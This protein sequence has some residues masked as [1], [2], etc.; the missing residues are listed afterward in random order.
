MSKARKVHR[1]LKTTNFA[2]WN[3]NG[4][5][6]EKLRQEQLIQDMSQ[7]GICF[8]ALQ[9]TGWKTE[10]EVNGPKG[11]HIINFDSKIEGYR[12][13]GFY[14]S[15]EWKDRI[16]TSKLVNNRI[17][18]ARFKAWETEE[19]VIINVYG[20]TMMRTSDDPEMTE[21]FFNELKEVYLKE[22]RKT[23]A[24]FIL[25]DFNAKIGR[26]IAED[27]NFMGNFGKG[28][29]NEN[30]DIL[31]QFLE[32][33]GMYLVNTH[34]R[35]YDRQIATWH[36]GRPPRKRKQQRN[37]QRSGGLHNQIDYIAIP[38]MMTKLFTD[39]KAIGPLK[40]RSDHSM[41]VGKVMLKDL[42]KLPR[43]RKDEK[44]VKMNLETL[45]IPELQREF[46][47]T[48]DIRIRSA[49]DVNPEM[50]N[51]ERYENVKEILR[52]TA[53]ETL[54]REHVRK[55]GKIRYLDDKIL[56][57]LSNQQLKLTNHIY[58]ISGRTNTVKKK[59]LRTKR[60]KIFKQIK[61]R[62][63]QLNE[64]RL[65][66]LA[67][68]L[69]NSKGNR[70]VYEVARIMSKTQNNNFSL[71]DEQGDKIYE[72]GVMIKAIT[73]FY[74]TF[75]ARQGAE[76]IQPWR[77][78]PRKLNMEITAEEVKDAAKRLSNH[79]ALGPD[80]V[81]GELIKNGGEAVHIELSNIFNSI[82]MMHETIEELK[83]GYLYALNKPGKARR[84][85]NTRPLVFLPA[86]RKVLSNIA[87][88][89][90]ST[91]AGDFLS[92]SQ[93]AYRAK[94]STTEVSMTA[95]WLRATSE[96]YAERIHIMGIDLSKAFDC[97]D[98]KI[99]M[100]TMEQHGIATEDDLRLI[101]F[102]ISETQLQVKIGSTF[103]E[104][105][106]TTI[107]T[108]QGD[109]LSPLLFLIYLEQIIRT[110]NV[111]NHISGRDLIY[112]YADDV[113]FATTEQGIE[114]MSQH[115][116]QQIYTAKAN[117]HCAACRAYTLENTLPQHFATYHMQMNATKTTHVEFEPGRTSQVSLMTLGNQVS[118][119]LEC[120]MRIQ[121]ANAAFN[122]M[123]SVWLKRLSTST[124]TKM[125]LYNSCVKSRLLYNAGVCTYTRVQLDKIDAAHRRHLRRLL[126]IYYPEKISNPEL[127]E[128]T[129][130]K[131]ISVTITGLRWT[132]LGHTLRL[133][134]DTPGNK[135]IKQYYQR[136]VEQT[137]VPRKSTNRGRVLTTLPRLLQLDLTRKLSA[138][139]RNENFAITGLKNG[140]D[141]AILRRK[142][143]NRDNWRDSVKILVHKEQQLWNARDQKKKTKRDELRAARHQERTQRQRTI[144]DYFGRRT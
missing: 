40:Y 81:D 15:P 118:G 14:I 92:L 128:R 52:Q 125:R 90:I 100:D 24:V 36:G 35:H 44:K 61:E 20:P 142:A 63:R 115:D 86:M 78:E 56:D 135:A 109:A 72:K 49:K 70:R 126:G 8:A 85:E 136:K 103:G 83:E 101:Q 131:P 22:K 110:S 84:A 13:L 99:L 33:T 140:T 113:N 88:E 45:H 76:V 31:R 48:V 65:Q 64:E 54:P 111:Q 120:K 2:T 62:I 104:K 58:H 47:E 102:L 23:R 9:E 137:D 105:F 97:I 11:E 57:A 75:F 89:R 94:R 53:E 73:G 98:R 10:A 114:R 106:R 6:H 67:T 132:M 39:A 96:R 21:A 133:P 139:E 144:Q 74:S 117:C 41:V 68:E 3:L 60:N 66:S 5:L 116:D 112:A 28:D 127:Y 69:E 51:K 43:V 95:Q 82:F 4:R 37:D 29:R 71:Y 79:R 138:R 107:G 80:N 18:V 42:Y 93:H 121:S 1:K 124:E 87:L 134:E 123:Q 91:K 141:L 55:N 108:P 46:Q 143:E 30:G 27:G 77:G 16:V 34:F 7:R 59:R 32:E 19:L 119:E 50:T 12:G 130:S 17:A 129:E 38:R 25:G 26:K 122:S